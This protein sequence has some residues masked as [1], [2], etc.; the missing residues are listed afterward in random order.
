[1][2]KAKKIV[3]GTG[4]NKRTVGYKVGRGIFRGGLGKKGYFGREEK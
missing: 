1:M 3:K 2:S 4:K